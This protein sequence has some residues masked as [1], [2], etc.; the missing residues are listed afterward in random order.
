MF[1]C[2]ENL[3]EID[4]KNF[5]I[6]HEN[7]KSCNLFFKCE[8]LGKVIIDKNE[9]LIKNELKS[10]RFKSVDNITYIRNVKTK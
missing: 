4:M 2:C 3:E 5:K 7:I 10:D 6:E 1:F 9:E 8:K